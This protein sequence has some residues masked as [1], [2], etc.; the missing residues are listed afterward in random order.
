MRS[1]A[2]PEPA[3]WPKKPQSPLLWG[4]P[5]L[6]IHR[7][8]S[9]LQTLSHQRDHPAPPPRE[10]QAP[11]P[12]E[13]P[14]PQRSPRQK[15]L[16]SFPHQ[17]DPLP[18]LN[19]RPLLLPAPKRPYLALATEGTATPAPPPPQRS[20]DLRLAPHALHLRELRTRIAVAAPQ[21]AALRIPQLRG[22]GVAGWRRGGG[23]WRLQQQQ[24]QRQQRDRSHGRAGSEGLGGRRLLAGTE[25]A[26]VAAGTGSL[27]SPERG[28]LGRGGGGMRRTGGGAALRQRRG[29]GG[30]GQVDHDPPPAVPSLG[31]RDTSLVSTG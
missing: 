2:E 20:R 21:L 4:P 23:R 14:R 11:S 16:Q 17:R 30:A 25:D 6:R 10:R 5:Q 22:E 19:P 18:L 12:S 29:A 26:A 27:T 1:R 7:R 13:G 28:S 15:G 9:H 24:Q 8:A 31:C 3:R